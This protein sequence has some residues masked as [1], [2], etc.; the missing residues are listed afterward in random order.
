MNPR[1]LFIV[2]IY[3]FNNLREISFQALISLT[4]NKIL[5][6]FLQDCAYIQ[7]YFTFTAQIILLYLQCLKHHNKL[8][9]HNS[10]P[11][12]NLLV[13]WKISFASGKCL[14]RGCLLRGGVSAQEGVCPV[15]VRFS[16]F[17]S[18]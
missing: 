1:I 6:H 11:M 10:V 14:P 18:A 17:L 16:K 5:S 9:V 2:L 3:R 4:K 15:T 7:N 8:F 13:Q 12:L